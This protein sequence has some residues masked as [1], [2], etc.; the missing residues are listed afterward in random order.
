MVQILLM[1]HKV[2]ESEELY[3]KGI[4]FNDVVA[5]SIHNQ[6]H[7][8]P[9]RVAGFAISLAKLYYSEALSLTPN[10]FQPM[11][12]QIGEALKYF[13]LA[14][15]N[16]PKSSEAWKG[17]GFILDKVGKKDEAQMAWRKTLELSPN[18]PDLKTKV[19]TP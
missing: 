15:E 4:Y 6:S 16:D 19:T 11:W 3:K 8:F 12:P 13:K 1:N 7:P 10:P 5:R 18:D 2:Q 14:T 17:L 9:D